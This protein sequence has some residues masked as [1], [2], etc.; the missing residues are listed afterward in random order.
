MPCDFAKQLSKLRKSSAEAVDNTTVFDKFKKYLHI[1]RPVEVELKSLLREVN[2]TDG[3]RLVLLCGSAG[4]GKSH[5]ISYL[6]NVDSEKLLS[7]YVLYN[8]ATESSAPNLTSIDTLAEKLKPFN[9][10]NYTLDDGFK[11]ILAINLGTLNNFIESEKGKQ[12]S[13]L[14]KYVE[15]NGIFDGFAWQAPYKENSVFHHI[16]FS[17]YQVFTL[18]EDGVSTEYLE[19]LLDKVFGQ[20]EK[21]PFYESYQKNAECTMCQRCPVRHNYEFLFDPKN[22]KAIINKIVEIVVKDKA[23]VS[24]RE[25]L[26]LLYDVIVH[27]KFSYTGLCQSVANNVGYLT[28]YVMYTT[29]MLL[30]EY[31]GITTVIDHIQKHDYLKDRKADMDVAATRFHSL[32]NIQ[33]AFL[34][35]A[36][37]TPYITLNQ[38]T[39]ISVL[40]GIK[41]ELKKQVY[42]FIVRLKEIKGDYPVGEKQKQFGE[43]IQYLYYQNSGNEKKLSKLYDATK[44]AIMNWDGQFESDY[45]CIDDSN[46]RYW[47]L[48]QLLLKSAIHKRIPSE[49]SDLLRFATTLKLRFKGANSPDECVADISIDYALFEMIC[50]MREGYRP[51]VQDKNRHTDFVSFVQQLIEFGNKATRI[52]LIPKDS[53]KKYKIVFEETDFDYEFKVVQA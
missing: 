7:E 25:I 52:T 42:R 4:D 15:A 20:S 49:E 14:K 47:V 17:D 37:G 40:G 51:T 9:D 35:A 21:N 38:I 10:E 22:R 18:R 34:D 48:E 53:D 46:E 29:P 39:D 43:Y 32:D 31:S 45:I 8:D 44:R 1:E 3:K 27:P 41:P 13:A 50:A 12:F 28:D 36:Q 6:R 30:Y 23:I 19:K 16:S 24:T 33:E 2:K 11:M 26:N 5:L